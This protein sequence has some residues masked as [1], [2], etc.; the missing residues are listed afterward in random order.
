MMILVIIN[1][2]KEDLIQMKIE[3]IKKMSIKLNNFLLI[4]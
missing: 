3:L 2:I 1:I 4:L